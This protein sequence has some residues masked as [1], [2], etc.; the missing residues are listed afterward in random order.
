MP[1]KRSQPARAASGA[2]ARPKRSRPDKSGQ[3]FGSG[4]TGIDFIATIDTDSDD[5]ENTVQPVLVN[6]TPP[7]PT[8]SPPALIHT[9]P[10]PPAQILQAPGQ[11]GSGSPYV[12]HNP[13]SP[14]VVN[15]NTTPPGSPP[16]V[17]VCS[18]PPVLPTVSAVNS[19]AQG[20]LPLPV[21]T[22]VA[23]KTSSQPTV[24]IAQ[25][26]VHTP[27][28]NT[29]TGSSIGVNTT[30]LNTPTATTTGTSPGS[31]G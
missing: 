3:Y 21:T 20:N 24:V 7:P 1:P 10:L 26:Q 14:V 19:P 27:P 6:G 4:K 22:T 9:A 17:P 2:S 13:P 30:T 28:M 25:A 31:A 8:L 16:H 15:N 29:N 5:D 23:A 18:T 11:Q 12:V